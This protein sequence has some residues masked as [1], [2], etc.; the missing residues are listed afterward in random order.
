M[1]TKDDNYEI[2]ENDKERWFEATARNLFAVT[3]QVKNPSFPEISTDD[4]YA[5]HR[6]LLHLGFLYLNPRSAIR[7]ENRPEIIRMWRFWLLP[8]LG[9]HKVNYANEAANLL[10]NL[11]ADWSP[12][13]AYVHT[14]FRTVNMSGR[15]GGGKPIDQLVE[16]YNL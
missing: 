14:N 5:S 3:I 16:H 6:A 12:T 11:A 10:A 13:V 7:Y 15:K 2:K 4:V 8:F 9:G 1:T